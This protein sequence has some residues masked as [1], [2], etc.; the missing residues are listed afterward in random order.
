[1]D[2]ALGGS[3]RATDSG[4][5]RHHAD[6]ARPEHSERWQAQ[7]VNHAYRPPTPR[8]KI[9]SPQQDHPDGHSTV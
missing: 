5:T 3:D 7:Q 1:M 8:M 2:H 6:T 9:N 4:L